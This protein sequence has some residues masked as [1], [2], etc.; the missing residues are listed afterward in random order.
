MCPIYELTCKNCNN[1]NMEVMAKYSEYMETKYLCA[2]CHKEMS[3]QLSKTTFRLYGDGFYS[4]TN[5]TKD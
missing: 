3:K 5:T 2:V 1:Y 4:P